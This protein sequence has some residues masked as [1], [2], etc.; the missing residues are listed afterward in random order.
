MWIQRPSRELV[1]GWIER[2]LELAEEGSPQRAKALVSFALWNDDEAA[3]R[4]GHRLAEQ[5]GEVELRS[6]ALAALG[7]A[8]WAA[9]DYE[10][11]CAL[12]EERL[13]LLPEISDPD[14]RAN[15][16][17]IAIMI[18]LGAGRLADSMRAVALLEQTAEG[19][20][21]HH[22]IHGIGQRVDVESLAGRWEE[23]RQLK[24]R[25]ERA[26]EANLATPCPLNVR[27]L[28]EC[29]LASAIGGD[30]AE[31]R[32][33]EAKADAIGMEGYGF[34][35]HPSKLR[36]AVA[37]NDLGGLQRLVDSL[38]PEELEPYA[39][40]SR[41]ALFD[42]LVALGDRERIEADAPEWLRPGTYVEPFALRA[43]G[44]A[45]ADDGLLE[46]AVERFEAMGL[47]WH[48]A[49]TRKLLVQA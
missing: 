49:E 43:L 23:A 30:D 20:T 35:F 44:F 39:Y 22:R 34:Y 31:A 48:T 24:S 37:R 21:P 8:R 45:R 16:Y 29:A 17:W 1:N 46:Q 10:G 5:L 9:V 28:L 14:H 25:V 15:V 27:S 12:A 47:D 41:S 11:A 26:V 18:Y 13:E 19:L 2:A 42:A 33:L 32:R 40:D 4:E 38:D 6:H 3:A 7:N 36:L